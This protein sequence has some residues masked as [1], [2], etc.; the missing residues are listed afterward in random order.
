[1]KNLKSLNLEGNRVSDAGAITITNAFPEGHNLEILNLS[2]A[3]ISS[4]YCESLALFFRKSTTMKELYLHF[5]N[6]N[7]IG[8][9]VLF[10]ALAKCKSLKVLDLSYN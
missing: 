3:N 1:M 10:K 5:N 9:V 7:Q 2:K 8:G 6:I 4:K